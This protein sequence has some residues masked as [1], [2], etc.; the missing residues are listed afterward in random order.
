MQLKDF[1]AP[2]SLNIEPIYK[3]ALKEEKEHR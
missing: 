3:K 2:S 1:K